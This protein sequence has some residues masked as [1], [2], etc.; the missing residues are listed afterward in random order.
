MILIFELISIVFEL[1][2]MVINKLNQYLVR[3]RVKNVNIHFQSIKNVNKLL[4]YE[5][6]FKVLNIYSIGI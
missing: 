6:L 4:I 1:V 3:Y 2:L 5:R